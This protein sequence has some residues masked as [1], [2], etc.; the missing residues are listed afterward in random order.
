M[1]DLYDPFDVRCSIDSI[2]S[3]VVRA[4]NGED[5]PTRV[6]DLCKSCRAVVMRLTLTE[7]YLRA[8]EKRAAFFEAHVPRTVDG[9]GSDLPAG[10]VVIDNAGVA[11]QCDDGGLWT[12]AEFN[13][14]TTDDHLEP[15]CG[16]YTIIYTPEEES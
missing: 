6:D 2:Q 13:Q 12:P 8:A 7:A 4:E 10:T 3:V 16:P 11:W 1:T 15:E 9:D 5:W 14:V